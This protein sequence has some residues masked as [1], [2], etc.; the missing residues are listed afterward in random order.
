[1]PVGTVAALAILGLITRRVF[2][3]A[4]LVAIL[5]SLNVTAWDIDQC[6]KDLGEYSRAFAGSSAE[7]NGI[8][9]YISALD[10]YT[11]K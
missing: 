9:L 10:G 4:Q 5:D 7:Q 3:A 11:A 8:E 1:M 6:K 2:S